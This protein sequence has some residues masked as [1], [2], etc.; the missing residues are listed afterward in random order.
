[1]SGFYINATYTTQSAMQGYLNSLNLGAFE[2]S[3]TSSL[4]L[5]TLNQ[6]FPV[7]VYADVQSVAYYDDYSWVGW[8]GFSASKDNSFDSYFYTPSNTTAP[9]AQP[10]TQ[11]NMN[12]GL[13]TGTWERTGPGIATATYYEE[14]G[15][16]LQTRQYNYKG[17]TDYVTMQ[18]DAKGAV[19]S[20]YVRHQNP[21]SAQTPQVSV[22][23]K[24]EYDH[25]GRLTK[26]WKK[27]NNTGSDKLIAEN[28]YNELGQLKDKKLGTKPV[29]GGPLETL[30]YG[31]NVR[32]WMTNI[33]KDYLTN[34][35]T[36]YFGMELAYDKTSSVVSGASYAAS[37]YNGNITGTIWKSKGDGVNRKYDFTY[38]NV[39]RLTAANF[40]Q[41]SG[42]GWSNSFID[43]SVSN[44]TYDVNGNILSM[45]QKGF[46]VTG[47]A[48]IDQL[49][50]AYQSNSNKLSQ[51][52]DASNEPQSKLGDFK[53]AGSKQ[54]YDY[55]YDINGN[56]TLDN[57]KAISSI[58]YNHLN[59]PEVI[60][61][62]G[63][64]T[65]T[66]TY[67]WGGN[68][69]KKV[70]VDNSVSPSVTTTTTYLNGFVYQNDTLQ[71]L[72]HEEGRIRWAR[73]NYLNGSSAFSY[74]YDYFL[75]DHLG[76]VRMVLTEQLDTTQYIA[77]MEAAYRTNENKLFYNIPA[78]NYSRAVV[79]GY[80]ADATTNPND[81]LMRL[82]GSGQKVGA[83]IILKVMS[84]DVVDIAVKAFYKDQTYSAPNN[85]VTD[86]LN[87]LANGAYSLTGGAKGTLAELNNTS[88]SP[89]YAALNSFITG[90][91]PT[92]NNKPRA[93]LN[94]IL[95]D[96]QF[97]YVNSY[98]QSGAL[99]V[100]NYASN[101]LNTLAYSGISITKNGFL[102]IYVNNE[103]PGWEVFFDNLSVK[104]YTGPITEE[105]HYYPFGLTMSN[106]SSKAAGKLTN[107]HKY[108]SIEQNN[109]FDLNTYEA[110]YRSLD[111][112]I[113]RFLQ[114][115][116]KSIDEISPY[117]SMQNN[118][119]L[120]ID[121]LGDTT[122]YYDTDGNLLYT[123]WAEGYRNAFV[124]NNKHLDGFKE[125]FEILGSDIG[126]IGGLLFD[127][128]VLNSNDKN[129][130]GDA[131]D[132]Q[133]ISKFYAD[134]EGKGSIVS[135]DEYSVDEMK[136]IKVN[137]K[138][139]PKE[140]IK[141]QTG[142]EYSANM[143]KVNGVWTVDF[144][145]IGTKNDPS[146]SYRG[147]ANEPYAHIHNY[148]PSLLG[149]RIDY[150]NKYGGPGYIMSEKNRFPS[151]E[152]GDI[153]LAK[154]EGKLSNGTLR[155]IVV[156]YSFIYLY[157]GTDIGIQIDRT[158]KK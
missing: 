123:T 92:I 116:P 144:N 151:G 93:H 66:Y 121:P 119:V 18:Y 55:S 150:V 43:F 156:T 158:H 134:H 99:A 12:L 45:N 77:T 68:K 42:G 128:Q 71:F 131:Y 88:T 126:K 141:K 94:W 7:I 69:L 36:S 118:P 35:S 3:Q 70:T 135:I 59:L 8:Y 104:H 60:T 19:L 61:V 52:N 38:D 20:T 32:G 73:R 34:A 84:G 83:A 110:F 146:R 27:L 129:G 111:P 90:N 9:Y 26:V 5:Y 57:N 49:T 22:Q 64:G 87:A 2:S 89:L 97:Q 4:P 33:N 136:S 11:S 140:F 133:S 13:P 58:T 120:L 101:T 72:G 25:A 91:N 50:Y 65:I 14:N 67:D 81:S 139:V 100:G 102:Y 142:V 24:M 44:L 96:E 108:N 82:N 37:Q 21:S 40:T 124:V 153:G 17:G 56:L 85:S 86:I 114:I 16:V 51:V 147:N 95:L 30:T 46:K 6:S 132:L 15:K 122:Y 155:N 98:P 31:Y 79:S 106:I 103:T 125:V 138:E 80:P 74:E 63:K 23:T 113:G 78:S 109:D 157:N 115:D 149:K 76:N 54:A 148:I 112:Q 1:M 47:P 145:A 137:G 53:Y 154:D 41:N 48:F 29:A 62:T 10:L 143:K 130:F 75:K 152:R 39:N 105:T 127:V 117:A 28:T 107:K